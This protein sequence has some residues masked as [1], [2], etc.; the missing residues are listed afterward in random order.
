MDVN[1]TN[2]GDLVRHVN[3]VFLAWLAATGQRYMVF[4]GSPLA[5]GVADERL[6]SLSMVKIVSLLRLA[7][8]KTEK[9]KS[10]LSHG[11]ISTHFLPPVVDAVR[12][13]GM[14][15]DE[16]IKLLNE[17]LARIVHPRENFHGKPMQMGGV[18]WR[19][20]SVLR[21]FVDVNLD[22]MEG[23]VKAEAL[24]DQHGRIVLSA[25]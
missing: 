3:D 5:I 9:R 21:Q 13:D 6:A 4:E 10:D 12:N 7:G 25:K 1:Q 11:R 15:A 23:T 16:A 20:A 22:R 24:R 18:Y 17:A 19:L 8:W 2:D 14:N